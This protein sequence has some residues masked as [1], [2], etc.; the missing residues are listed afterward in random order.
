MAMLRCGSGEEAVAFPGSG[1]LLDQLEE[2]PTRGATPIASL[3]AHTA[4]RLTLQRGSQ[5]GP[6]AVLAQRPQYL[7]EQRAIGFLED[8][9]QYVNRQ[10]V[11]MFP[12]L[13]PLSM[14]Q[15]A[16]RRPQAC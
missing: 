6:R 8:L 11:H 5:H 16:S 2:H 7:R 9:S 4:G 3:R 12:S 1:V 14:P 10:W 15:D 13:T